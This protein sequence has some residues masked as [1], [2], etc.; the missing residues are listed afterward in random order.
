MDG[1][2]YVGSTHPATDHQLQA[3]ERGA[4]ADESHGV[5]DALD[6]EVLTRCCTVSLT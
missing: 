6:G 3:E 4:H 1:G 2:V 5:Q